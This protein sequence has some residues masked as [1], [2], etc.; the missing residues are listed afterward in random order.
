MKPKE[1]VGLIRATNDV[2]AIRGLISGAKRLIKDAMTPKDRTLV[3]SAI[4]L[5][6]KK[7]A[8]EGQA[9]DSIKP[10]AKGGAVTKMYNGGMASGKKHMYLGGDS[11]VKDNAGLRA[12]KIK[13]PSTY[14][15]ITGRNA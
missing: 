11:S 8:A 13:S 12:L 1:I 5:G 7:I 9:N 3:N 15:K 10:N 6:N 2:L 4:N 14:T